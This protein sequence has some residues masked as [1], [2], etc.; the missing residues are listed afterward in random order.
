MG[1][2]DDAGSWSLGVIVVEV[3]GR[4]DGCKEVRKGVENDVMGKV[5]ENEV[6]GGV[7]GDCL[8]VQ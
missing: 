1:V 8:A 5:G 3:A 4:V 2:I 6:D 7:G